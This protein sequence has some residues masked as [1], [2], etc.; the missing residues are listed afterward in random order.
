VIKVVRFGLNLACFPYEHPVALSERHI[1]QQ[2]QQLLEQEARW[3]GKQRSVV[4]SPN[5][6][7]NFYYLLEARAVS[8][9]DIW[10]VGKFVGNNGVIH[11]LIEHWNGRHWSVVPSPN[12]GSNNNFLNSVT[13]ISTGDVWAVGTSTNNSNI[14]RTLIE[15]WNGTR[16]SIIPS[17]NVGSHLN[18]LLNALY[19]VVAVSANN[20]WTVG[21][22]INNS[23]VSLTLIQH[24][25]GSKWS[26]VPSPNLGK[27]NNVLQGLAKVSAED[28]WAVGAYMNSSN[29]NRTLIEHC[30]EQYW[31]LVKQCCCLLSLS[32]RQ[33]K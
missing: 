25:N 28:V 16:W 24:W 4:P 3:N 19:E 21:Q 23:N 5:P 6:G 10:S 31:P 1:A 26:I 30:C 27:G 8:A 33:R 15:H 2:Q 22:S 12:V 14:Q 18:A 7:S 32:F 29:I 9:N 13:T 20:I 11:T 17:P